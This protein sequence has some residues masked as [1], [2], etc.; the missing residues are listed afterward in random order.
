MQTQDRLSY[1]KEFISL[2]T[3]YVEE[4]DIE[5]PEDFIMKSVINKSGKKLYIIQSIH[6]KIPAF[7]IWHETSIWWHKYESKSI[8]VTTWLSAFC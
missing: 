4:N 7:S 5:K 8:C 2:I 3:R 1:G 6:K